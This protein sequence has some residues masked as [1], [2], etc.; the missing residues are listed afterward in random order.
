[1]KLGLIG[2]PKSGKTTLFNALTNSNVSV[3]AYTKAEP[4]I[5]VAKVGDERVDRLSSMYKPKKTI[6]A[7][8]EFLDVA[9]V[10][11][12]GARD[13]SSWGELLKIIRNADALAIVLRNFENEIL[14]PLDPAGELRRIDD[15]LLLS[16]LITVERRLEKIEASIKKGQKTPALLAEEK[17]LRR[18]HGHL[19][20]SKPIRELTF[21]TEEDNAIRG[22]QFLTAKPAIAIVNSSESGYG[23]NAE[24]LKRLETVHRAIEFAGSFEMELSRLGADE[25]LMFMEDMGIKESARDRLTKLAY[26]TLGYICFFT[27][28][29]DEVRA[30]T[31]RRGATAVEAAGTIHSDLARG[32]IAAECFTYSDLIESGSEK[33]I[34][35][36]GKLRIEGKEYVVRDGDILNIR[37]NV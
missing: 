10:N 29:E 33:A 23:K 7:T 27:V 4:N 37:F 21:N 6:H 8:I 28:G 12:E 3:G 1:V 26:E 13:E 22:F 36:K 15:E 11:A 35:E 24:L 17:V 2:L 19:N 31:I 20:E 18:I 25:A 16:D 14:G 32:F 5:A 30:W 34:K 9:G